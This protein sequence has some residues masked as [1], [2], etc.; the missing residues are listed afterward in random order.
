MHATL[1]IE[2]ICDDTW[3]L[4]VDHASIACSQYYLVV[5]YLTDTSPESR[6]YLISPLSGVD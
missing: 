2:T 6:V 3:L 4:S 5:G 1:F